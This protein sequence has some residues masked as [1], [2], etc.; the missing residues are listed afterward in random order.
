M[1]VAAQMKKIR[2]QK[3]KKKKKKKVYDMLV[4]MTV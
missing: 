3:K 4:L 1:N 2:T